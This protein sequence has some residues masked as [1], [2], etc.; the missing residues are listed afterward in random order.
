MIKFRVVWSDREICHFLL[1]FSQEKR[2]AQ[3]IANLEKDTGFKLRVLAQNYPETPGRIQSWKRQ[4]DLYDLS[5]CL[6]FLSHGIFPLLYFKLSLN[7]SL[8]C[9]VGSERFLASG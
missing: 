5:T 8:F 2:L 3:E 4:S 1:T 9:R 7:S 6:A